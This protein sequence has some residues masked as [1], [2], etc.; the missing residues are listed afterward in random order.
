MSEDRQG[1]RTNSSSDLTALG[2]DAKVAV[3]RGV[4]MALPW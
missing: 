4:L 2:Q 1:A 3:S